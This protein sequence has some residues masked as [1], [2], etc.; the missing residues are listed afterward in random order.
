M[1]RFIGI[2]LGTTNSVVAMMDG[3]RPRVLESAEGRRLARSVVGLRRRQRHGETRSEFLVGDT[4]LDNWP[5]APSDTVVS[6]KRLMG[7][8]VADPEVEHIREWAPYRIVAPSDGTD[9]SVRVVLG[10]QE[11]SPIQVSA[12]ILRKLKED[13]EFRLGSEVTHA[14][15]TVPAYFSHIQ[16]DATRKAGVQ[17]GLRVIQLLDEPTAAAVAYG[18]EAEDAGARTLLVYDLGGG[19]FDISV[20]V[21]SGGSFVTLNLEGD[22]WL[23]GDN[24]D[25]VLV[26]HALGDL[27][28]EHPD[29]DPLSNKRFMAELKRAAQRTRETLSSA[30]SADLIVPGLL[31]GPYGPV[32]LMLEVTREELE[33]M[34]RPLVGRTVTLVGTALDNASLTT[35]DIDYVLM[36]GNVTMTPLVQR[37]M[38]EMFGSEKVLRKI[39]PKEAV[40]LGAATV[41]AVLG[42]HMV[43]GA[44]DPADPGRECGEVNTPDADTC[45]RCG[46]TLAP[47]EQLP[48]AD[49]SGRVID[50][51]P[52]AAFHYGTRSAHDQFTVFVRKGDPYPTQNPQM[53]VFH[54]PLAGARMIAIPIHGGD[55]LERAS[56]NERQGEA[57]AIL[58]KELPKGTGIRIRLWLDADGVCQLSAHLQ[59]GHD[60]KPLVVEK[61]EALDRTIGALERV[62]ELLGARGPMITQA[63]LGEVEQIREGVFSDMLGGRYKEALAAVERL[64][65]TLSSPRSDPGEKAGKLIKFTEF[66]LRQYR[67]AFDEQKASLLADLV[68]QTKKARQARDPGL[69]QTRVEELDRATDELPADVQILLNIRQILAIYIDPY[70]PAAAAGLSTELAEVEEALLRNDGAMAERR[71]S[72]LAPRLAAAFEAAPAPAGGRRCKN[73]HVYSGGRICPECGADLWELEKSG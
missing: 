22:M 3:P 42:G 30:Q 41:A 65:K 57:L 72:Q 39:Q 7:R 71:L 60:L 37:A 62:E 15:I 21:V 48:A 64:E 10:S 47:M 12:M 44:A 70:D 25:Q 63:E 28:R 34:I 40:A 11:Y 61:G 45:Q 14:V 38:E 19:T 1:G 5:L 18:L 55:D 17:A 4:A 8:G 52:V 46:N 43:C 6:V 73:G 50:L 59:D 26:E 20:L 36:A 16:K 54:T 27:R 29:I 56:N 23:G 49:G 67:W 51:Q 35:N 24:F 68:E 2:D 53:H 13:A 66:I 33:E 32:D 58:P 9:A 31:T 69:L